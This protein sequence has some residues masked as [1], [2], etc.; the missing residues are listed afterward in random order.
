MKF[1]F[2]FL[3]ISLTFS[4]VAKAENEFPLDPAITYGKLE[5]GLTFYIRE[6]QTPKDK[7]SIK[8]IIKAGSIMEEENQLGL[9]H[10]LEHM[11]FNGSK[12][13]PKRK[14]DAVLKK[15]NKA[16]DYIWVQEEPENM[17]AWSFI[18]QN[19]KKDYLS[20]IHISEPTRPY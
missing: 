12:N 20:L 4:I 14:I 13:F 2:L 3:I 5:N 15:Y 9:A 1:N 18:S 6:N 19:F 8:L 16:K 17:G 7:V 11:A 10:L